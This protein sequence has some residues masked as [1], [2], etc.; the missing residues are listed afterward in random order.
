MELMSEI[1]ERKMGRDLRACPCE[2]R[3]YVFTTSL[4]D[5]SSQC[6]GLGANAKDRTLGRSQQQEAGSQKQKG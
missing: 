6:S 3:I 5:L 2:Q 1:H 4:I